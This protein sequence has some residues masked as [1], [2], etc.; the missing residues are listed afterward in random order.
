MNSFTELINL[1]INFL[2]LFKT[3]LIQKYFSKKPQILKTG[4]KTVLII[5]GKELCM[6]INDVR[7]TYSKHL[8]YIRRGILNY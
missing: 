2:K 8:K 5:K 7:F 1:S 4:K 6:L 3:R